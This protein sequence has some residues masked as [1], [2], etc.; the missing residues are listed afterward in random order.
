MKKEK[1]LTITTKDGFTLYGFLL[2]PETKR[3]KYPIAIFA[4]QFGTTHVIW[5][6]LA[7]EFLKLGI[8]VFLMDLRGHGLSIYQ[9][10]KENRIIF[11]EKYESI[12][13]LI[14][15]FKKSWKKVNFE[16]IPEDITLWIKLI[17]EKE[18]IDKDKI[19]LIGSSLGGISII[20]VLSMENISAFISISPG[21]EDI[22]GREKVYKA[23]SSFENQG[24][25]I[26]SYNDLLN[27][28]D[29]VDRMAKYMKEGKALFV[30]NKG[31]GVVLLPYVKEY[32]FTFIKNLLKEDI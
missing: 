18:N 9:N 2:Y 24:L 32:I 13:D 11:N 31:H 26:A 3:D 25:F 15:F 7:Q 6:D 23:L 10:G 30:T 22:V 21:T 29:V 14:N 19:M 5:H 27:S 4:H 16:K 8:A 20:P 28:K 12:L 17:K 1:V